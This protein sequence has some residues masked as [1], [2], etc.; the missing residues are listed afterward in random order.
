MTASDAAVGGDPGIRFT[1][2]S[3]ASDA[4][5]LFHLPPTASDATGLLS[6]YFSRASVFL[7]NFSVPFLGWLG[8][9]LFF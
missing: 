5:D 3:T 8:S 9:I 7:V 4:G 1:S 2:P 6:I